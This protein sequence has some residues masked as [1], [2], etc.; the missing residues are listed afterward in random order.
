M[1]LRAD[2]K[3]QMQLRLLSRQADEKWRQVPLRSMSAKQQD[4]RIETSWQ[5]GLGSQTQSEKIE[6]AE[7]DKVTPASNIQKAM[8]QAKSRSKHDP[9]AVRDELGQ[10]K[11]QKR[12]EGSNPID[13][14]QRAEFQPRTRD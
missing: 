9:K 7:I 5:G 11:I 1:D 14:P 12:A 10:V 2:A 4:P 13:Q 6:Y 8:E 3:R